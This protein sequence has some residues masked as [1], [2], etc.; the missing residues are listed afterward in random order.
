MQ[1]AWHHP[2]PNFVLSAAIQRA[3]TLKGLS[4]EHHEALVLARRARATATNPHSDTARA[5]RHHLLERWAQQF[6]PHF[7]LEEQTLFPALARAGHTEV[8]AEALMQHVALR[9]L[10]ARLRQDDA[11]ALAAWGDALDIHVR[12]EECTVFPLAQ[13]VLDPA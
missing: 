4:L 6:A 13:A 7:A 10:V 11:L 12:F 1:R 9:E 2:L 3:V 8:A 5:Q